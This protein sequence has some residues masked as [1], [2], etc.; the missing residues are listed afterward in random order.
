MT[1]FMMLIILTICTTLM[2]MTAMYM[3]MIMIAMIIMSRCWIDFVLEVR[4]QVRGGYGL[5]SGWIMGVIAC[6]LRSE[7]TALVRGGVS[8]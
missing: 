2:Y 7:Q 1:S 4:G 8:G 5:I 6:L 3:I